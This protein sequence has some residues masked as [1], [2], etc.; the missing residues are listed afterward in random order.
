MLNLVL[1]LKKNGFRADQVQAFYPSLMASATTMYYSEKNPLHQVT[2]KSE[3]V[4]TAKTPEQRKLH[5]APFASITSLHI[6]L[7]LPQYLPWRNHQSSLML[8]LAHCRGVW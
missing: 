8:W 6:F 4:A 2:Y 3:K 7:N 5:K 1:W